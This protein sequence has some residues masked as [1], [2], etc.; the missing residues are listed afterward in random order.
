MSQYT[1]I[2]TKQYRGCGFMTI[3]KYN[4]KGDLIYIGDKE[5][6]E[7][8]VI[9]TTN[10]NVI[11]TFNYHN[12]VIWSLDISS[13]DNILISCSGDFS[14]VFSNA[15][16][17]QLI[18]NISYKK[19]PKFI[20]TQ[21]NLETNLVAIL[22]DPIGKNSNSSILIYDLNKTNN[23]NFNFEIDYEWTFDNKPNVL[24]WLDET[25]LI[26]G[27]NEGFIIIIDIYNKEFYKE[28]KFHDDVIKSIVFNKTKTEILTSSLDCTAKQIILESM[29]LNKTY[30]SIVPINY[31]QFNH[32]DRKV[33][34]GGGNEAML[35]SK[36][37]NNDLHFKIFRTTDQKLMNHIPSHFG[38]IRYIDKSPNSKN[39]ISASQD[40]TIR[41][42]FLKEDNQDNQ[43]EETNDI[44]TFGSVSD[45]NEVTL[46]DETLKIQNLTWKASKNP[47]KNKNIHLNNPQKNNNLFQFSNIKR[48]SKK[49]EINQIPDK[50][51]KTFKINN[52]LSEDKLS[53][54]RDNNTKKN[55][56]EKQENSTIRITNLPKDIQ[57]KEL[58]DIFETFGRIEDNGIFIK[59]YN[60]ETMAFVR[61]LYRESADKAINMMNKSCYNFLIL[62]VEIAKKN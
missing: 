3:S 27:T 8:T 25:K 52:Y 31:A 13:D 50:D 54:L 4:N 45:I 62:T 32:N 28:Y 57:L 38:P 41:I 44:K 55:N 26:V 37:S 21:K 42:Y 11:G 5:S 39:F 36:L 19:I 20:T 22:S 33:F 23:E 48:E 59:Y 7:I 14:I 47:E 29:T 24:L 30:T 40:G 2:D 17:G 34:V 35:V 10:Y 56:D 43:S 16:N 58:Y 18:Y 60:N 61:Y 53:T 9:E 1:D 46:L 12:G 15:K 6:K 49:K 51:D